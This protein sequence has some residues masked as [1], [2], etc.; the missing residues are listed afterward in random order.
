MSAAEPPPPTPIPITLLSGFLGAGKTTMLRH[1]LTNK[2][3]VRVG[4]IVNDVADI[5][6][7]AKLVRNQDKA[8]EGLV[9]EDAAETFE[10]QNG[11][12]CCSVSDEL[13]QSLDRMVARAE[14]RGAPFDHIV[15]ESSGVAE[16]QQMRE[17][18]QEAILEGVGLMDLVQLHTMVT[19]VDGSTFLDHWES[20]DLMEDRPE[21]GLD[22]FQEGGGERQIVDLLV[23]QAET[24]DLVVLNKSDRVD[25]KAAAALKDVVG[26][27]NPGAQLLATEF[28][29][30][31]LS[32]LLRPLSE[33][34][35][36]SSNFGDEGHH[37]AVALAKLR[38]E[39][40]ATEEKAGEECHDEG[41]TEEGHGH[42]HS[43][44]EHE[45]E[46]EA[47]HGHGHGHGEGVH[48]HD[49][50][51]CDDPSHKHHPDHD[52][53][54]CTDPTHDHGH[55]HGHGHAPKRANR[56]ETVFGITSFVYTRRRPFHPVKL[57]AVIKS[58]PVTINDAIGLAQPAAAEGA[59][60]AAGGAPASAATP[61]ARVMKNVIRSK[62]FTWLATYHTTALYWSHAGSHFELKNV[63]SWWAAVAA[64]DLPNGE[65]PE[66]VRKDF[67]K[68]W[69]D[70]RQELVFIGVGMGQAAIEA[71]LDA[72]LLSDAELAD[73]SAH[74]ETALGGAAV[75]VSD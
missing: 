35:S 67:V 60:A 43:H 11:C 64:K 58:L 46:K 13:F 37:V 40:A 12:A 17:R 18:F 54:A 56:G 69:G 21:L 14:E 24:A 65:V 45:K 51:A 68:V 50:G 52:A 6:I 4:V 2:Q 25:A 42:G 39:S 75:H 15:I 27:L 26:A 73:Y 31:E 72:C 8:G 57:A 63:G 66:L 41:C 33:G 9:D 19:V 5:N 71:A 20:K 55:G 36:V 10:L 59:A 3:G 62:G 29:K 61:A 74:W 22:E 38:M 7:D 1:I 70:R 47:G 32:T 44:G 23:E 30:V 53:A 49:G 28:G 16:P 48:G 34:T